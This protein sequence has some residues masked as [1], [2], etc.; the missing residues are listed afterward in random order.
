MDKR[1]RRLLGHA[2]IF[3]GI[4]GLF[5]P[6]L[7]GIVPLVLGVFLLQQDRIDALVGKINQWTEKW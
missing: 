2:L 4:L 5:L 1:Y 7:D 6:I 3:V